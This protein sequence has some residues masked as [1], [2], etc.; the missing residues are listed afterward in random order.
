[1][2]AD[3]ISAPELA[4]Y[5]HAARHPLGESL[6]ALWQQPLPAGQKGLALDGPTPLP[7]W[8]ARRPSVR[9]G[10]TGFPLAVLD[11]GRLLHNAQWMQRFCQ[12]LGVSLA[13]HGKTTMSPELF[14]LQLQA[15]AWGITVATFSQLQAAYRMGVRRLVVANQIVSGAE[16][17]ALLRLLASDASLSVMMLVDA[18]AGVERLRDALADQ[19]LRGQPNQP[20]PS[21]QSL[22]VLLELG[23][24]QGRAG[25]R[26]DAAALDIARAIHATPGL[27]LAGLEVYEGLFVTAR[28][29]HDLAGVDALLAR[30]V[31]LAQQL[32]AAGMFGAQQPQAGDDAQPPIW[33]SA[34]GSAFFDRVARGLS[35]CPPLSRPHRVLLRSGCYL[36]HDH[37]FYHGL[38]DEMAVREPQIFA[39][40][41]PSG[42][43]PA[44]QVWAM[45]QS[46]PE[47]GLAILTMGKRDASF[48]IDLPRPL[49]WHRPGQPGPM[50]PVPQLAQEGWR[51]DRMNDQ[52]AYL[53]LPPGSAGDIALAVG[54]IVACGIS[55]PC[56]TF[57]R[58]T[59]L[60]V[61]DS[62]GRVCGAVHTQF[63]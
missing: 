27:R 45:V 9:D 17:R 2:T 44:L 52:H 12:H 49:A 13:P 16:L 42:L 29:E 57:D 23:Q 40:L 60:P 46:R 53:R 37:G 3:L 39:A 55:H 62:D 22:G 38:L 51:I 4:L 31:R 19:P 21:H 6:H 11:Q 33:L 32:D 20:H 24:P 58:W 48:D 25:L 8:L 63:G 10:D 47:P 43:L 61:C 14:D 41:P 26:D 30:Q 18:L 34:G 1:M 50:T 7:A 56:T 15:G 35:A 36:T 5:P 28:R 54:D 59:L